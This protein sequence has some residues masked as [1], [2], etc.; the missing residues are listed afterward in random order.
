MKSGRNS[1]DQARLGKYFAEAQ[2]IVFLTGAGMSTESGIPDFRSATG[3]YNS[4]VSE[5]VFDID[6]F[7]DTPEYFYA[8]AR[9]FLGTIRQ[10]QPHAGH[11]A[12]AAL[13]RQPGKQVRIV[14]QNIDILHQ[15]AGSSNVHEV[16]GSMAYSHC[17]LCGNRIE[18]EQL[19]PVIEAG[20]V[21]RHAGCNGVFKPE[22]VFFGEMLPQDAF[23]ASERAIAA[24]DL[25]V[26]AGTSL[27]VYPA[28]GLP[29][30]RSPDCRLVIIN[31][32]P[33]P[34]DAEADLRFDQRIGQVLE[35][36]L[37]HTA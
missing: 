19:W 36:A 4:G 17:T 12:M 10:A 3:L 31:Q 33:T 24:A 28:A 25:L 13:E 22:I 16:H 1:T 15:R 18:T 29:D 14:T 7:R 37:H 23:T 30:A 21:P 8:F 6:A 5:R 35:A 34:L 26:I 9:T 32:T 27:Q 2:R 20:H 11:K